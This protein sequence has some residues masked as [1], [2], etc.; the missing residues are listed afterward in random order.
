MQADDVP[1]LPMPSMRKPGKIN[2]NK[3]DAL[4]RRLS[5]R[6]DFASFNKRFAAKETMGESLLNRSAHLGALLSQRA[7]KSKLEQMNIIKQGGASSK[8]K[9]QQ[10][11]LKCVDALCI[12]NTHTHNNKTS[13]RAQID[14]RS[15]REDAYTHTRGR[16][17][18]RL[19]TTRNT[20]NGL[21]KG[22]STKSD[23]AQRN[24]LHA[25]TIAE[26]EEREARRQVQDA[27]NMLTNFLLARPVQEDLEK[28]R[29]LVGEEAP[30]KS[31]AKS[32]LDNF[33]LA[34]PAPQDLTKKKILQDGAV[35]VE[36]PTSG[37]QM[38]PLAMEK[39][40]GKVVDVQLGWGHTAALDDAGMVHVVG[41]PDNGRLGIG[42]VKQPPAQPT[43]VDFFKDV[44]AVTSLACGDNH[45]AAV[46][47][48]HL[49]T[50]GMGSWGRLGTGSQDDQ[51]WPQFVEL[52]EGFGTAMQVVCG[53][54]H[55]LVLVKGTTRSHTS[56]RAPC[57]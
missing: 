7:S 11:A 48:S 17:R 13:K 22:R 27:K 39:L 6:M 21:L 42:E 49:F 30:D 33:L 18:D 31:A 15:G 35:S 24:I 52:P 56:T 19:E 3:A 5:L 45:S 54:Y 28:K 57:C 20:L 38:V 4:G 14:T 47:D 55:T 16:V 43:P 34:R 9:A 29:I 51:V 1:D 40:E 12:Y 50:W 37:D 26:E 32:M 46:C 23:L 36:A 41:N 10:E 2:K 8:L 25:D 44:G 53:A